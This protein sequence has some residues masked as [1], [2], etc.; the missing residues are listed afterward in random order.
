[1]MT[2]PVPLT[3]LTHKDPEYVVLLVP[4][5]SP[6]L[7]P[8]PE[9]FAKY[10]RTVPISPVGTVVVAVPLVCAP[11]PRFPVFGA[12]ASLLVIKLVLDSSTN[13]PKDSLVSGS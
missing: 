3:V 12:G 7:I 8:P 6:N 11:P 13:N 4:E 5:K 10:S 9:A 2:D 1:M